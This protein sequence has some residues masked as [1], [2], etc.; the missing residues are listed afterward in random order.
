MDNPLQP[1]YQAIKR[2]LASN[3]ERAKEESLLPPEDQGT[4]SLHLSPTEAQ[5]DETANVHPDAK[6]AEETEAAEQPF[7]PEAIAA[8]AIEKMKNAQRN[9]IVSGGEN[10]GENAAAA[11]PPPTEEMRTALEKLVQWV[12][13]NGREFEAKVR[14]YSMATIHA[15][16]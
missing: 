13:R 6:P 1:Y 14:G 4:S 9:V 10:G 8:A 12:A 3:P 7:D 2:F 11:M 15:N 5:Q 16:G